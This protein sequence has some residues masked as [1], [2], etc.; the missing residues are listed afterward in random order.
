M[1]I[2]KIDHISMPRFV[3]RVVSSLLLTCECILAQASGQFSYFPLSAGN[4]W[5]FSYGLN[6]QIVYKLEIQKDTILL[7]GYSYAKFNLYFRNGDSSFALHTEGYSY[8]RNENARIIEYPNNVILG[9]DMSIGDTS[10][11]FGIDSARVKSVSILTNIDTENVF[12]RNL[13]TYTFFF[14]SYDYYT[15]SDSVGFNTLWATTWNNWVP[16]Y[17]LGCLIDGKVYGNTILSEAGDNTWPVPTYNLAQNYPNPFNPT[18][19]ISF[20][21]PFRSFVSLKLY[22]ILGKEV[23]ALVCQE[24]P[25]GHYF[26]QWNAANMPSGIYFCS[27][28]AGSFARI[29]KL[30]LLR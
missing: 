2:R 17:L 22:D 19:N 24:L 9:F 23:A 3:L 18:T 26:Q 4:Q 1:P 20:D 27:M 21:I 6:G 30:V 12:G 7:D 25:A 14:T 10:L 16:Q 15:F 29:T 28:Q 5:F 11:T 13:V 8:L